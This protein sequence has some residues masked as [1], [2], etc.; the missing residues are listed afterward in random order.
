M[1]SRLLIALFSLATMLSL[2]AAYTITTD[3]NTHL[4]TVKYTNLFFNGVCTVEGRS[5]LSWVPLHNFWTTQRIGQVTLALP[6]NY[7]KF[8]LVGSSIAPGNAF[9][10]LA[11]A[12]GNISTVAGKGLVPP[13]VNA[14]RTNYEGEYATNVFLSDPRNAVADRFGNIYVVERA[15]HAVRKITL[16]GR[17]HTLIGTN[18]PGY[19]GD[20]PDF[21]TNSP[22]NFPSAIHLA[23]DNLYVLDAGN[24]RV[25]VL[26]VANPLGI[27][28]L[29]FYDFAGIGPNSSGLWVGQ[30]Q[31]GVAEEAF[32]GNGTVLKH[33]SSGIVETNGTGFG[34]LRSVVVNPRGRTIVSDP[35]NHRVYRVRGNG[36]WVDEVQAGNGF[37]V[38]NMI[39]GD[40]DRVALPGASGVAYLPIGGYFV[41]LDQGAKV[42]YVDSDDKAAPFIFGKPG[43]R[44]GDGKWFRRG[45]RTPKISNVR[46]ISLAPD[47]DIILLESDGFVRK[48]DFLRSIP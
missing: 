14:W 42:W 5:R 43:V 39:G 6:T 21:G 44:A 17:I 12:Y 9:T 18:G 7:T 27:V 28:L 13:G 15:G 35:S 1:K 30:N 3:T 41:A 48:V 46:S 22:L 38:G 31:D 4:T 20:A 23:G 40:A 11:T 16:D 8:R 10:R 47:G 29:V 2:R 33:W 24:N 36:N 34:E 26:N 25:R 19:T 37:A 45:G 32:Y